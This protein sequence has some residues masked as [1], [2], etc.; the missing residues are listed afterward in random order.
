MLI[1][2]KMNR[3]SDWGKICNMLDLLLTLVLY[4]KNTLLGLFLGN[5]RALLRGVTQILNK[6]LLRNFKSDVT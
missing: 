6:T 1:L 4:A 3:C 5:K 2:L